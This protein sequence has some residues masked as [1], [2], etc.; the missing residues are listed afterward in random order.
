MG[1][2]YTGATAVFGAGNPNET[3]LTNVSTGNGD[4]FLARFNPDGNF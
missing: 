2:R 1:G 4:A 3:T